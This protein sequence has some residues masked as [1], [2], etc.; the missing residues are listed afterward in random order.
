MT[1]KIIAAAIAVIVA[2]A[3]NSGCSTVPPG[4]QVQGTYDA[5]GRVAPGRVSYGATS[6]V[7]T[8][9][10]E[11]VVGADPDANV[12]FDLYRNA[13]FHRHGPSGG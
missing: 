7:V 5:S 11:G 9:P 6:T 13:D 8:V 3:A 10:G 4:L 12:R 2:A 1:F